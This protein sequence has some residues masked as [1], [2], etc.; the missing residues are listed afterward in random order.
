MCSS[1]LTIPFSSA[2]HSHEPTRLFIISPTDTGLSF[3]V[4]LITR[5]SLVRTLITVLVAMVVIP[6]GYVVAA[7]GPGV[8]LRWIAS[9]ASA[10]GA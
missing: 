10:H 3:S 7:P 9:F 2:N 6:A 1:D 8:M 4:Y 5:A